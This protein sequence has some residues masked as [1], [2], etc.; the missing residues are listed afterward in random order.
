MKKHLVLL[1]LFS[2]GQIESFA[3]LNHSNRKLNGEIVGEKSGYRL[4][5]SNLDDYKEEYLAQLHKSD[6]LW[7]LKH[8]FE[9]Y[10]NYGAMLIYLGRYAEAKQVFQQI[11]LMSPRRY[12]TAANLGT[13]YELTGEN[14]SALFWI[15]RAVEINPDAH[16]GSEWLHIKILQAKIK[17]QSMLN[18]QFMLGTE[19][20]SAT[21]PKSSKPL[22]ELAELRLQIYYQLK[23]RLQFV[24]PK[25]DIV[26]FLLFEMGTIMAITDDV[27][28]ALRKYDLA[29][30]Y[31][32]ESELLTKRYD[33]FLSMQVG[34]ENEYAARAA[35]IKPQKMENIPKTD[36]LTTQQVSTDTLQIEPTVVVKPESGML[37]WGGLLGLLLVIGVLVWLMRR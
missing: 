22:K 34:L 18:E 11:E 31:G 6:S 21:V 36:S 4:Y 5:I 23:E 19:F 27:T 20:G 26:G 8:D 25:D 24:K 3:C 13:L 15:S 9:D 10:N 30:K 28:E 32:F 2:I 35:K 29:R 7:K 1:L 16:E 14:D 33:Y 37:V 17:G 12:G